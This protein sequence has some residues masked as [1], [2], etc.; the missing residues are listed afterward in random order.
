MADMS[1]RLVLALQDGVRRY[2]LPAGAFVVGGD[3]SCEIVLRHLTVSRRHARFRVDDDGVWLDD[4]GSSNGTHVGGARVLE[5]TRVEPGDEVRFGGVRGVLEV[6]SDED[7]T[8]LVP[9]QSGA[10][11]PAAP[12]SPH[13]TIEGAAIEEFLLR[14]LPALVDAALDGMTPLALAQSLGSGVFKTFS[15]VWLEILCER[16]GALLFR[17]GL[18][19]EQHGEPH[20]DLVHLDLRWRVRF[21]SALLA[22]QFEPLARLCLRLI[23]TA[24]ATTSPTRSASPLRA[25]SPV[26]SLH[27]AT[28]DRRLAEL[29]ERTGRVARGDIGVLI[30]GE[31]GTGKEVLARYVHEAS[32]HARAPFVAINCASLPRDL[33]EAELF[34]IERAVAT[35]VEA[36]PGKFESAHGG[37]LFL[38]E[39]GDMALGT[40]ATILRVLQEGEVFRLGAQS[41]RPARPRIVA[42][43]NRDLDE[44]IEQGAFRR[45]L[46]Y[47]IAGFVVDLPAL[48]QRLLD[49]PNLAASFLAQAGAKHGL[50]LPGLS[51]R[52]ADL[53]THYDWPGNIRE[54]RHEMERAA[55][56]LEDGELL[57]STALDARFRPVGGRGD[58]L[59][60]RLEAYERAEIERALALAAGD[61]A[62]AAAA[63]GM[64]RSTLYRRI[65]VLGLDA[66]VRA[67]G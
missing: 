49:I 1:F 66:S 52:A 54:L 17:G 65:Q 9:P 12:L 32:P 30:R 62:R 43:T 48:R 37:T 6:I 8:P 44:L 53:L 64:G 31:S 18:S 21:S 34:G 67:E 10:P 24:S 2:A 55:L 61:V 14:R 23:H 38:D 11:V 29:L 46:Y 15:C 28:L 26:R 47:R 27:H 35:G 5:K 58:T 39:V 4:L 63:L 40:Q 22:A 57:D 36:R 45:D 56:F 7:L 19:G 41:A 20:L 50:D 25:T 13:V 16:T 60:E 51:V 59:R 33:L 3:A 42:A